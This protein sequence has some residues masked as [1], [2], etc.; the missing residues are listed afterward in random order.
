M[1]CSSYF[2]YFLVQSKLIIPLFIDII[3]GGLNRPLGEDFFCLKEVVG[4]ETVSVPSRLLRGNSEGPDDSGLKYPPAPRH[5]PLTS[6][7]VDLQ[8][9]LLRPVFRLRETTDAR[10]IDDWSLPARSKLPRNKVPPSGKIPIKGKRKGEEAVGGG[11]VGGGGGKNKR[12]KTI[13]VT[14]EIEG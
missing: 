2:S 6:S 5:I 10:L 3:S 13:D 9:G 14:L 11:G 8:I 1:F 4:L 12:K 7:A